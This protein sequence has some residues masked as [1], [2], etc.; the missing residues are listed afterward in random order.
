MK[1]HIWIYKKKKDNCKA[2]ASASWLFNYGAGVVT[3]GAA[4]VADKEPPVGQSE[5]AR[6]KKIY[7]SGYNLFLL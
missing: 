3:A 5:A 4:G 7:F 2:R 6:F 1:I